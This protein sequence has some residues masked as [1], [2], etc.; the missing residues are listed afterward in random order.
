[1]IVKFSILICLSFD[2]KLSMRTRANNKKRVKFAILN[3][4]FLVRVDI[5]L[6]LLFV[7]FFILNV[8]TAKID[9]LLGLDNHIKDTLELPDFLSILAHNRV[10]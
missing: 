3:K 1:M 7:N 4:L 6:T 10:P 8:Q 9:E 5:K 2:V